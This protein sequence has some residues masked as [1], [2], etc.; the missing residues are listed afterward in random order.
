M[1]ESLPLGVFNERSSSR[2]VDDATI[3]RANVVRLEG[4]WV[5]TRLLQFPPGKEATHP[6]GSSNAWRT[7]EGAH[8]GKPPAPDG[9]PADTPKAG[10]PSQD[11]L[12]FAGTPY[13]RGL[14]DLMV[15]PCRGLTP[16]RGSRCDEL[17]GRSS[18][19]IS[20]P[21]FNFLLTS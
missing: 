18:A 2:G 12:V 1:L 21:A 8:E 4:S 5:R 10:L 9:A 11:I 13:L 7:G 6:A 20:L 3:N 17:W 15:S 16:P 19:W 14:N